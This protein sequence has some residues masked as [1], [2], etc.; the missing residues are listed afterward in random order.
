[1]LSEEIVYNTIVLSLVRIFTEY[2]WEDKDLPHLSDKVHYI[3]QGIAKGDG[4]GYFTHFSMILQARKKDH[5]WGLFSEEYMDKVKTMLQ[6]FNKIFHWFD[7][8]YTGPI[9]KTTLNY[10]VKGNYFKNSPDG[11]EAIHR[12]DRF[13]KTVV[14][15]RVVEEYG[16]E[17]LQKQL[18][19]AGYPKA[20]VRVAMDSYEPD[21]YFDEVYTAIYRGVR[22]RMYW[23][24]MPIVVLSIE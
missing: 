16:V 17:D 4:M 20:A 13:G 15:Y 1:M 24:I 9:I 19:A 12:L 10:R 21:Y 14:N 3:E 2:G 7:K 8:G 11:K 6:H 18:R 5:K 22:V 23:P